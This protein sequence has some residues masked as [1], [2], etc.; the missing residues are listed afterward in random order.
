MMALSI[1]GSD[2]KPLSPV[3]L[4]DEKKG[5]TKSKYFLLLSKTEGTETYHQKACR[6]AA[7][8]REK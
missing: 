4:P 2:Q 8:G 6:D 5:Y 3:I 1:F 7:G